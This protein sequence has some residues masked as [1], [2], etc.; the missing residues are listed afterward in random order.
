MNANELSD[1]I[2]YCGDGGYNL[3]AATMLRQQQTEIKALKA[4]ILA[5][6]NAEVPIE[7][8]ADII[9]ELKN[10]GFIAHPAK[11]LTNEE[12]SDIRDQ[13][14]AP[15]ECNIY[16]FAKAILRKANEK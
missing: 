8:M 5:W 7:V 6:E 14:F 16:T 12:I 11:E 1:A 15:D 9:V 13:F 3:D 4:Q 10:R 2:Q